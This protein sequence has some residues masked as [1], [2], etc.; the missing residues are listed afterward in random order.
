MLSVEKPHPS[1][2][3]TEVWKRVSMRVDRFGLKTCLK[4]TFKRWEHHHKRFFI[5]II[6]MKEF[7]SGCWDF[8]DVNRYFLLKYCNNGD[9]ISVV[10]EDFILAKSRH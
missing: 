7:S 10:W 6:D 1:I 5:I 2:G 3:F 9:A 4:T 8:L